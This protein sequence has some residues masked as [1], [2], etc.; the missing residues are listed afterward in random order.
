MKNNSYLFPFLKKYS[1][2]LFIGSSFFI[3][4]QTHTKKVHDTIY[5]SD[6]YMTY[7]HLGGLLSD[8][9]YGKRYI[10][11]QDGIPIASDTKEGNTLIRSS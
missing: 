9:D 2:I 6:L 1:I 3:S 4:A 8:L 11:E 5:I 10:I 7:L